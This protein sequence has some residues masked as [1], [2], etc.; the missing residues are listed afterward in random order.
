MDIL[1][2]YTQQK[3]DPRKKP[4]IFFELDNEKI[5]FATISLETHA[6]PTFVDELK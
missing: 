4:E 6:S 2:R 5:I 1:T 3:G